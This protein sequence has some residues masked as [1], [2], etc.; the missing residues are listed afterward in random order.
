MFFIHSQQLQGLKLKLDGH[1]RMYLVPSELADE[2][3]SCPK[4]E[5]G[6]FSRTPQHTSELDVVIGSSPGRRT[7]L[8][9]AVACVVSC[10]A[11]IYQDF[12]VFYEVLQ[13][14]F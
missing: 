10:F 2:L 11:L 8:L 1:V 6:V 9:N 7:E 5:G 13:I 3:K 14:K 12:M 4:L